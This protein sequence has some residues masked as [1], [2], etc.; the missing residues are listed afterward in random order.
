MF[1]GC[2]RPSAPLH[3][4]CFSP[5]GPSVLPTS[6]GHYPQCN[7]YSRCG[8]PAAIETGPIGSATRTICA[9]DPKSL[10]LSLTAAPP[11]SCCLPQLRPGT[12]A[13]RSSRRHRRIV[14]VGRDPE[15]SPGPTPTPSQNAAPHVSRYGTTQT[16]SP[17]R[18]AARGRAEAP[19]SVSPR[20]SALRALRVGCQRSCRKRDTGCAAATIF[21]LYRGI[22][23]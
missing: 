1:N 18:A 22:L 3:H 2:G 23:P 14:W 17:R 12:T 15:R 16:A 10:R 7:Q 6:A 4:F 21:F 5:A 13:L 9:Y 11:R 8:G 19:F 20:T